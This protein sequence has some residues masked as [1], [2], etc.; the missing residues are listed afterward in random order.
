LIDFRYH[1][2]SI[3]AVFLALAIGLIV[4]STALKPGVVAALNTQSKHELRANESLNAQNNLLN[5][6]LAADNA[7]AQAAASTL[8][9]GRLQGQSVVLVEA[10]GADSGMVTGITAAIGKAGG[11]VTGQVL[12]SQQFFDTAALT[13]TA[14]KA[15]AVQADG[16]VPAGVRL[17]T[18][19]ATTQV[20]GQ[21]AAAQVI[22]AAIMDKYGQPTMS[23]AQ[24]QAILAKFGQQNFL[25]ISGP[26]GAALS[27]QASLAVVVIPASV[28]SVTTSGPINLALVSLT[29]DLQEISKGAV[30]AGTFGGS[31]RGS[32]IDDVSNGG[33]VPLTTV[34]NA[35][36]E[37]GQII[38]VQALNELLHPHATPTSY[39]AR[40]GTV[41]SP[42]PSALPSPSVSPSPPP[43]KKA[44]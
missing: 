9:P 19:Q 39:G 29:Q 16:I 43:K 38:V 3:V 8:L 14:L 25:S 1:L 23:S 32:V 37:I 18:T 11:T 28:P 6:Q 5:K 7:F 21:Q 15:T 27:G 24:T 41:P 10:P 4:G 42:A 12:L 36:T 34:D 44:S 2:V 40:A 33:G 31:G 22:A 20:A 17:P 30:M 26:S 13:E 35:D